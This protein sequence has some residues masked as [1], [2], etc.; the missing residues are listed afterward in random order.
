MFVVSPTTVLNPAVLEVRELPRRI[1]G[2]V[3]VWPAG[4]PAGLWARVVFE[5][6]ILRYLAALLPFVAGALVWQD[7][8]LAIAQAP[9]LMFLVVYAAETK[10]LRPGKQGRAA[11]ADAAE[12]ERVADLLADR[13]RSVLT[14]IAA[15]RGMTRGGLRL[16]V[17]QSDL[18][19]VAPLTWVSVQAEEG[20]EVLRLN[21]AEVALIRATLFA[22]ELT[23]R[24][25]HRANLAR[26]DYLT[27]VRL[28]ARDLSAHARLEAMMAARV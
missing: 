19:R 24:R 15:G 16:V 9:L 6:E 17:E 2:R 22:G 28:D 8:A 18:A 10:L 20:P 3:T 12:I 27:E 5:V 14:R 11:L 26:D 25:L 1:A 21:P 7:Q 23:E 4:G 13:G